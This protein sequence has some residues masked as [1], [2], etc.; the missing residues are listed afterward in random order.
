MKK[1]L[2]LTIGVLVILSLVGGYIYLS[3]KSTGQET[4][5]P[6]EQEEKQETEKEITE[7][8]VTEKQKEVLEKHKNDRLYK[9]VVKK[10]ETNTIVI[11]QEGEEITATID[12]NTNF[13]KGKGEDL[14]LGSSSEVTAG[15]TVYVLVN[16]ENKA[17]AILY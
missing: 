1:G 17:L 10:I 4:T 3:Q 15:M 16:A 2:L 11:D 5:E 8:E 9:G 13:K 14:K 7:E 12:A 6:T